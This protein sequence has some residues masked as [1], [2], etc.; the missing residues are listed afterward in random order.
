MERA[1]RVSSRGSDAPSAEGEDLGEGGET[2]PEPGEW[3][4][5]ATTCLRR[6]CVEDAGGSS[7]DWKGC[8]GRAGRPTEGRGRR[9][10][11]QPVAGEAL[12]GRGHTRGGGSEGGVPSGFAARW[13][14]GRLSCCG[15][16]SGWQGVGLL[17]VSSL[18]FPASRL[19]AASA[20]S[21]GE[22]PECGLPALPRSCAPFRSC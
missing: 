11:M 9:T 5:P 8:C 1:F 10:E 22:R 18:D 13:E 6:P 15:E 20:G 19:K 3:G 2:K 12:E 14:L 16:V 4:V 7:G 21:L 17:W